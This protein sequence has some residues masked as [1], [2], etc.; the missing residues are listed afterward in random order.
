MSI[1]KMDVFRVK[2]VKVKSACE[3]LSGEYTLILPH[4]YYNSFITLILAKR[5]WQIRSLVYTEPRNIFNKLTSVCNANIE[6]SDYVEIENANIYKWTTRSGS[7][8]YIIPPD[9]VA[10]RTKNGNGYIIRIDLSIISSRH[11]MP[12]ENI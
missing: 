1:S 2:A 11:S 5:F 3:E 7:V 9:L 12:Y 4:T 8:I 6:I 10:F